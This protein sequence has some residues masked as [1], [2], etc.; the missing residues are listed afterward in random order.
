MNRL[1]ALL[2]RSSRYPY[3]AKFNRLTEKEYE[4]MVM[5]IHENDSLPHID[6]EYA[7]N[8]M[9]LDREKPKNWTIIQE[10]LTASNTAAKG[11]RQKRPS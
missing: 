9:F 3:V 6:Y 11:V 5:F 4:L 10:L 1:D 8:R 2:E 7:V